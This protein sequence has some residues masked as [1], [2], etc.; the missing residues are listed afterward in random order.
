MTAII[1]MWINEYKHKHKHKQRISPTILPQQFND[2]YAMATILTHQ[3]WKHD[4]HSN[5]AQNV[6]HLLK[7]ETIAPNSSFPAAFYIRRMV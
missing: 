1:Q 5:R 3:K 7:D 4:E 6:Q 2:D